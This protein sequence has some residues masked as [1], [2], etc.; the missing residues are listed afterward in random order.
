MC[1]RILVP[2]P[3]TGA[4][5]MVGQRFTLLDYM[6]HQ[7]L[8]MLLQHRYAVEHWVR[9]RLLAIDVRRVFSGAFVIAVVYFAAM[10]FDIFDIFSD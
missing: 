4:M 3:E 2:S 6:V 9:V 10:R 1:T 7:L 8:H 5:Q